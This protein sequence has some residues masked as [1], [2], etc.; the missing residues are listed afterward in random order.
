M[1]TW[2][3]KNYQN[4]ETKPEELERIKSKMIRFVQ[5]YTLSGPRVVKA[6]RMEGVKAVDE[7]ELSKLFSQKVDA[8]FI[9]YA[10]RSAKVNVDYRFGWVD[11][12]DLEDSSN[13]VFLDGDEA[14]SFITEVRGHFNKGFLSLSD[15][16][17]LVAY[18]YVD[19][20][21]G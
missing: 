19:I 3:T 5:E 11:I 6:L 4:P 7:E 15:C 17:Y 16:E 21:G 10:K 14:D 1:S 8:E 18:Q 13:T 12:V 20:L 9:D 2:R